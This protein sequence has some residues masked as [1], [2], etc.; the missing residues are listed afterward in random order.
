MAEKFDSKLDLIRRN[1][2]V[3]HL[4]EAYSRII[5][6]DNPNIDRRALLDHIHSIVCICGFANDMM[7][8]DINNVIWLKER[9]GL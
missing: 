3:D 8:D 9:V 7:I 2:I 5:Q 4:N 6:L 1:S